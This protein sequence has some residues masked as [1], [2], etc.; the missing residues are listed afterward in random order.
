LAVP[1]DPSELLTLE[2]VGKLLK[3]SL[4]TV[5][6]EASSGSLH[7]V[8]LGRSVRVRRRDLDSYI[9]ARLR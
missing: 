7:T 2:E 1:T 3:L 8:K 6:R 5:R 9:E 4:A